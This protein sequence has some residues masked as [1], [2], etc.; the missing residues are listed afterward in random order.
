MNRYV[1]CSQEDHLPN[2]SHFGYSG[3]Y[4][5]SHLET[6]PCHKSYRE[7]CNCNPMARWK[8]RMSETVEIQTMYR[9]NQN[10][11]MT[12][13][14]TCCG[15]ELYNGPARCVF[16]DIPTEWPWE[17]KGEGNNEG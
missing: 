9:K 16:V 5:T 14:V 15:Q 11:T 4:L 7:E 10:G 8:A 12:E 13:R 17:R 2:C 6:C 1:G 3:G